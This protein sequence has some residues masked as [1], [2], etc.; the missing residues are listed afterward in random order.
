MVLNFENGMQKKLNVVL[1]CFFAALIA[2]AFS[3][4]ELL[5]VGFV[6]SLICSVGFKRIF[7]GSKT[8]KLEKKI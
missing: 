7:T 1:L 2:V 3:L 8:P 6:L 4:I 5:A